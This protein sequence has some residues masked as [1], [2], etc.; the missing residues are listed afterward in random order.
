MLILHLLLPFPSPPPGH[1]PIV[2]ACWAIPPFTV[3]TCWQLF[4][5][6]LH[7]CSGSP[8]PLCHVPAGCC[9]VVQL[10]PWPQQPAL[11]SSDLPL[12]S[13]KA[14]AFVNTCNTHRK[15][16]WWYLRT[17]ALLSLEEKKNW[18]VLV[19]LYMVLEALL[20]CL[21]EK[22]LQ[23]EIS[24]SFSWEWKQTAIYS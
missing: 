11:P 24:C 3:S 9:P 5:F 4:L 7:R 10:C 1:S 18:G 12:P 2:Q 19:P 21:P 15:S 16:A 17:L 22:L 23:E 14:P 6:C 13:V 8:L 20:V